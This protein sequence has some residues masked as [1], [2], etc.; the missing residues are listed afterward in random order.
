MPLPPELTDRIIGVLH[1]DYLSLAACAL[2]ATSW[3]PAARYH[4]FRHTHLPYSKLDAFKHLLHGAP[5]LGLCIQSLRI[6]SSHHMSNVWQHDPCSFLAALPVVT[7]LELY[8]VRVDGTLYVALLAALPATVHL[9]LVRCSFA[10]LSDVLSLAVSFPL[11]ESL[12]VSSLW[13]PQSTKHADLP[14]PPR[15]HTVAFDHIASLPAD[16]FH[17]LTQPNDQSTPIER[18]SFGISS[19]QDLR[20]LAALLSAFGAALC[21]LHLRVHIEATLSRLLDNPA[22]TLSLAPCTALRTL[23]L[24]LDLGELCVPANRSLP[25]IPALLAQLPPAAPIALAITLALRVDDVDTA[26]L[27]ALDSEC[28]VRAL[29]PVRFRDLRA[30]DWPALERVL[31]RGVRQFSVLGTGDRAA[32]E[33]WVGDRCPELAQRGV[34]SFVDVPLEEL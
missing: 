14:C 26:D 30:L 15:L 33:E 16:F 13:I 25:A 23:S 2:T 3:L 27:R 29:S 19:E 10:D 11:L 28:G 7:H 9:S 24:Q 18:L 32:L 21:H 4:R 8:N 12:A 5:Q 1:H 6:S 22:C 20:P 31:A 34:L 17:W